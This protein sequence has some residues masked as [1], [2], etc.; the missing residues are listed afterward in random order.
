MPSADWGGDPC[1][2][3]LFAIVGENFD[4]V[5]I[6]QDAELERTVLAA[7]LAAAAVHDVGTGTGITAV[8]RQLRGVR[9]IKLFDSA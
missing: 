4:A 6:Q 3:G 8:Q 1:G 7:D 9:V 2:H 5:F